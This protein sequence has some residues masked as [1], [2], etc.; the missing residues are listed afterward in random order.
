MKL[1]QGQT[2]IVTGASTG[3]GVHIAEALAE[4]GVHIALAARNKKNLDKVQ[5]YFLTKYDVK[6]IAI[7]TDISKQH[8]LETL[9]LE[10]ITQFGSIDILVNNAGIE[11][12]LWFGDTTRNE[13][14]SAIDINLKGTLNLTH[15]VLPHMLKQNKGHIVNIS[16]GTGYL[17]MAY[18]EVYATTKAGIIGFTKALRQSL[19]DRGVNVSASVVAPGFMD[20][21]GMYENMKEKHKVVAP[22]I[23]GSNH[24]KT[25]TKA[26]IKAIEKDKPDIIVSA[27][28]PRLI[29]AMSIFDQRTIERIT[30][31]FKISKFFRAIADSNLKDSDAAKKQR[32]IKGNIRNLTKVL[33][34]KRAN[35][36]KASTDKYASVSSN[37]Q[38]LAQLLWE[39]DLVDE[40]NSNDQ[41]NKV[42]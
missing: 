5:A 31:S 41:D 25:L 12:T 8:D 11:K 15:L 14:N 13:I 24:M 3:I 16:S 1:E 6:V 33:W 4:K 29:V 34:A 9:V 30:K 17:P 37:V 38:T 32:G 18:N 40:K 23:L 22:K 36:T 27:G 35:Q 7:P 28:L 42:G 10:T 26:L 39:I 19:Q 2:A 20:G 21:S